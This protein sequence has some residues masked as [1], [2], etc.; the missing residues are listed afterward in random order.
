M[1]RCLLLAPQLVASLPMK[2]PTA[3]VYAVYPSRHHVSPKLRAFIEIT[4][5]LKT[6]SYSFGDLRAGSGSG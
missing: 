1:R 3:T 4:D 2:L 5:D 6:W